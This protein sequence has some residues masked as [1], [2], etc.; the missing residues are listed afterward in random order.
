[1]S[2]H[3]YT[4]I[5]TICRFNFRV[6]TDKKIMCLS[7]TVTYVQHAHVGVW[8]FV[9]LQLTAQISRREQ[10]SLRDYTERHQLFPRITCVC[11]FVLFFIL[12][13][14]V[15]N[16]NRMIK[17]LL[18]EQNIFNCDK[19]RQAQSCLRF[20]T[21]AGVGNA[22]AF[23]RYAALHSSCVRE[24]RTQNLHAQA[25][26]ARARTRTRESCQLFC[27]VLANCLGE[28][29]LPV[30]WCLLLCVCVWGRAGKLMN[31]T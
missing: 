28:I 23:L 19:L 21:A 22:L 27:V 2:V 8:I 29:S 16:N 3:V 15:N 20:V 14:I 25:H 1:M 26:I 5:P 13:F 31:K 24:K 12:F 11:C 9:C 30:C 10:F 7:F 17:K 4:Y 18:C 6:C